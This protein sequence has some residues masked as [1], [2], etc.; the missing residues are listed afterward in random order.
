MANG[1]GSV[2]GG[3]G[4]VKNLELRG[5]YPG[6]IRRHPTRS[7]SP[8]SLTPT[9]FRRPE[10]PHLGITCNPTAV[11]IL[12]CR[13][14][15]VQNSV[16]PRAAAKAT[17]RVSRDRQSVDAPK[18]AEKASALRKTSCHGILGWEKIPAAKSASMDWSI[19]SDSALSA[20]KFLSDRRAHFEL[21]QLGEWRLR[22][23]LLEQLQ[24]LRRAC[25]RTV[26]LQQHTGIKI[27]H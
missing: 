22:G 15:N 14:S 6:D 17:C 26:K 19:R 24:S 3:P 16:A 18:A 9:L 5:T 12:A 10:G 20:S 25:L 21:M 7:Q 23:S 8:P 27:A 11:A 13:A 4:S 1:L 2:R